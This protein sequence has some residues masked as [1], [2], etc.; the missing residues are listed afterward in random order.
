LNLRVGDHELETEEMNYPDESTDIHSVGLETTILD[1]ASEAN[2]TSDPVND[3]MTCS[4]SN[5][6][7]KE[8]SHSY[9]ILPCSTPACTMGREILAEEGI[10]M[11]TTKEML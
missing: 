7:T 9:K 5:T 11:L 2:F 8:N 10:V 3:C 4:I 6:Y 1:G